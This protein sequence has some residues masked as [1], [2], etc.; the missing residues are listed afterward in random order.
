MAGMGRPPPANVT[1]CQNLI[2]FARDGDLQWLMIGLS[3][4][5]QRARVTATPQTCVGKSQFAHALATS[6]GPAI[7]LLSFTP[8]IAPKVDD[9]MSGSLNG[10]NLKQSQMPVD[11]V[12]EAATVPHAYRSCKPQG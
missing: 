9:N 5:Q 10:H 7:E 3:R 8:K 2:S 1:K 4:N 12:P 11:V 6:T